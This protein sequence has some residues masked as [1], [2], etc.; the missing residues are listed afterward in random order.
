[1]KKLYAVY[2]E[3]VRSY[4]YFFL[5]DLVFSSLLLSMWIGGREL[6]RQEKIKR[7]R[8]RKTKKSLRLKKLKE[9]QEDRVKRSVVRGGSADELIKNIWEVDWDR[10]R[11]K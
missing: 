6:I 10:L 11:K 4:F 1:M 2:G 8:R 7:L 5:L 9:Q 3:S